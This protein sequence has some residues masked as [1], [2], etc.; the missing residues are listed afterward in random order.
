ME[1]VIV[2]IFI[3]VLV[4][5]VILTI[6]HVRESFKNREDTHTNMNENFSCNH[7]KFKSDEEYERRE[8]VFNTNGHMKDKL[9]SAV[10]MNGQTQDRE[11]NVTDWKNSSNSLTD[12]KITAYV[13]SLKSFMEKPLEPLNKQN[14]FISVVSMFRYEDEYLDEWLKYYIMHGIEHFFLYSNENPQET[15][16]L[17]YPYIEAGYVTFIEWNNDKE[18][19]IKEE[20]KRKKWDDYSKYC[21]QNMALQDFVKNHKDKTKW[22]IKI[23][24]DEFVYPEDTSY[25]IKDI[26]QDTKSKLFEVPRR[27]FGNNGHKTKPEGL[28]IENYIRCENDYS[29]QKSIA[30]TK[31]ISPEDKGGAH[32]FDML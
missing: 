1:L 25:L 31:F 11:Y 5:I 26:L 30:L 23:D 24:V 18:N 17:L 16:D 15:Y 27:D 21:I 32:G 22:I 19:L 2:I 6:K 8:K 10:D 12:Y 4:P 3:I 29:H 9:S 13:P 7:Y 20:N 14:Y 28:M